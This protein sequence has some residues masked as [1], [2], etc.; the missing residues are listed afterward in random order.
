MFKSV[1]VSLR[2]GL[3]V[4]RLSISLVAHLFLFVATIA[5]F[6]GVSIAE[7][8]R[9]VLRAKDGRTS[10]H[11]GE[12]IVL[13][14]ACLDPLSRQYLSPCVVALKAEPL[15]SDARLS[16]DRIDQM[17]WEDAQF[18]DLPPEPRGGCGTI[19]N[20][21]PSRQS[22]TPEWNTVNLG[23]PFPVYPGEYKLKA[24]LAF[25]LEVD[26]RFGEV[27]THSSSD[28]VEVSLDDNLDWSNHL[29]RFSEC[30]YDVHLTLV[31]D[32]RAVAALRRHLSDCAKTWPE[33]YGQLLHEVVWL[34]MQV[35]QPK[36]YSRMLELERSAPPMRNEDEAALQQQEL[37]QARMNAASDA[38]QIRQ[39]FNDQYRELLVQTAEQLVATYKSHPE[40]RGDE[41]FE[42][43]LADGFEN[44]HDAAASL[45]GGTNR[46]MS[47]QEVLTYL[48]RAGFPPKYIEG[49]LKDH[50][51][52]LPLILPEYH[53]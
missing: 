24:I 10:F 28:E 15:S 37:E 48:R 17:T 12:P 47:R 41:D 3:S 27:Q 49:F 45:V 33:T 42:S 13:E 53:E 7:D 51:S 20:R 23:E 5:A 43:D 25:D 8:I 30:G 35:E 34:K 11:L 52:D 32:S 21:L 14:A 50:K 44:W 9:I 46:Y 16:A 1:S 19:G 18:G 38:N 4:R 29:T 2:K 22:Q 39:W 36:L 26:G 40:L 31:P 6:S